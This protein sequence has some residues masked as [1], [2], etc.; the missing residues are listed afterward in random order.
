MFGLDA[1]TKIIVAV[2]VTVLLFAGWRSCATIAGG[3]EEPV[4]GK[5]FLDIETGY[6][7]RMDLDRSIEGW[8][9]ESSKTGKMTAYPA[10]ICYWNQ[11]RELGGTWVVLNEV[12]G[13][14]GETH[15]PVCGREVVGRNPVPRDPGSPGDS[16]KSAMADDR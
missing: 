8:P 16:L 13:K 12:L 5:P 6:R 9:V 2:C 11:C 3:G 4:R 14:K 7:F 1:K 10:E 15:C